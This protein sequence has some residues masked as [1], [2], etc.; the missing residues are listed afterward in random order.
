MAWNISPKEEKE[1]EEES[2]QVSFAD[3]KPEI[4]SEEEI[5]RWIEESKEVFKSP[6]CAVLYGHDG[7]GKSGCALDCRTPEEIKEGWKIYVIDVDGS[8]EPLHWQYYNNDPNIIILDPYVIGEDGKI[9]YVQTYARILAFIKYIR[10]RE[11]KEKIKAVILDGVDSLLKICEYV[12]K[13][14]DLKID[15]T[16]RVSNSWDWERRNVKFRLAVMLL[17]RMRCH[18]F[19]TT[20]MKPE[21]KW[22]PTVDGKRE[23]QVV[24]EKPD[25]E[26][27]FPGLMFQKI[28]MLKEEQDGKVILKAKVEKCKT[29]LHLEGK[30]YVV[31]EI[32]PQSGDAKWNGLWEF[33]KDMGAV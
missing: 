12:M 21:Y 27:S 32:D 30:E 14:E 20:H 29:H 10:G 2:V 26:R 9:D 3:E 24:D 16:A 11:T 31:A 1:V 23:L 15:P 22:L 18:R 13:I 19:Y 7:T 25:W 17:K 4:V 8:C 28:H 5:E 33:F 6:I